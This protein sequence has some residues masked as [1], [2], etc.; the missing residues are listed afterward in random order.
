M[1]QAPRRPL[2]RE[3]RCVI[4][5]IALTFITSECQRREHFAFFSK[6][7]REIFKVVVHNIIYTLHCLTQISFRD[8]PRSVHLCS[9]T[10]ARVG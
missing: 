3:E 9:L 8:A 1:N 2:M 4:I 7:L 10:V 6:G 5:N